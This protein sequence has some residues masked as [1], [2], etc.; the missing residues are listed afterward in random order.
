MREI[1]DR[2]L[3]PNAPPR[4]FAT[5][6]EALADGRYRVADQQQRITIVDGAPGYLP[7]TPVI[8]IAGR[9]T[10]TGS[11]TPGKTVRV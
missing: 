2:L 11:R 6:R 8:I 3:A 10:G 9:I 5:V 4:S 1:L 7:G